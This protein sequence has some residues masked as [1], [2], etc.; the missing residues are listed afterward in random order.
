MSATFVTHGKKIAR[1][2]LKSVQKTYE[3]RYDKPKDKMNP[4]VKKMSSPLGKS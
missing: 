3:R 2:K 1:K 4:S